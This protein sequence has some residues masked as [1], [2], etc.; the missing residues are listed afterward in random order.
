MWL[1][2]LLVKVRSYS[3]RYR[4]NTRYRLED[5]QIYFMGAAL[6]TRNINKND[7]IVATI[8]KDPLCSLSAALRAPES[9]LP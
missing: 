1:V 2:A 9:S 4:P 5:L 3:G 6:M 8:S 7:N